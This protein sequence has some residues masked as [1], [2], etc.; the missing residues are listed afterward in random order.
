MPSLPVV[1]WRITTWHTRHGPICAG[2]WPGQ[3]KHAPPTKRRS[4]SRGKSLSGDFLNGGWQ[5]FRTKEA[6][7]NNMNNS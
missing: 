6:M 2:G 7:H 1:I 4:L 5:I 3:R